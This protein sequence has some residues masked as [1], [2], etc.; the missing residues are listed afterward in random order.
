MSSALLI[1]RRELGLYLRSMPG[2]V[3][4]AI[5]LLIDGLFF[6]GLALGGDSE[7]RSADVLSLFFFYTGGV[8][9]AASLFLSMRFIAEERQTNT[10]VLLTSSPVKDWQIVAGKYL[11]GL[12]YLG[13]LALASIY[14]PVMIM[15]NGKIS[16]GHLFAGY[17]GMLLFGG[18][19]LA[20]GTF[21]SSLVKS[22][23]LAVIIST[24]LTLALVLVWMLAKVT[25]Q[26]FND[27]L[28]SLALHGK[29]QY[30]F[31][32]GAIHGRDVV[33]YA[34]MTYFFLFASTRVME[35]RRWR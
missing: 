10:I 6:Q 5:A 18:T 1:A 35:A 29:H 30:P 34:V 25:D 33:Y 4:A 2:Y 27:F 28:T 24:C 14:M 17:L 19:A 13:L 11:A 20:I 15:V 23:L 7:R 22:Q 16:L 31:N 12:I 8:H 3:I 26:P 32:Q 21:A 9:V